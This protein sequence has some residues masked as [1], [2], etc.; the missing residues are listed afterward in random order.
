MLWGRKAATAGTSP[1]RGKT[2]PTGRAIRSAF[3]CKP[4]RRTG[5]TMPSDEAEFERPRPRKRERLTAAVLRAA[6]RTMV[7]PALSPKVPIVWQRWWLAQLAR[8]MRASGQA[9]FEA[10]TV[11]GVKG[12][13]QGPR[14]SGDP[15]ASTPAPGAILYLR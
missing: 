10:G 14:Q 9:T 15:A 12:E 3:G 1:R 6:L 11:G 5:T 7:K 4:A 13:W 8:L 2:P